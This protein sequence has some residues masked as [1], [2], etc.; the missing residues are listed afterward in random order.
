MKR[1]DFL[2][3]SAI[4]LLPL[5]GCS[6]APT[7]RSGRG[8]AVLPSFNRGNLSLYDWDRRTVEEFAMP[9]DLT[10]SALHNPAT[11]E[12]ILFEN[13]G[14]TCSVFDLST[15]KIR[16]T[17]RRNDGWL[18]YGHGAL[19]PGGHR[20][21][22]TEF[23]LDF[24][25]TSPGKLTVRDPS[26]LEILS[27]LPSHGYHPHDLCFLDEDTI[28]VT[29]HGSG[30]ANKSNVSFISYKTGALLGR[31]EFD[32]PNGNFGHLIAY[33]KDLSLIHI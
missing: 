4:L 19:S 13:I 24:Y 26:S 20:L 2:K 18:F 11:N 8:L 32:Q 5:P 16:K 9:M 1:R 27:E 14:P 22:C 7:K 6:L 3:A 15:R 31:T 30:P 17:L 12:L 33:G 10:H 25:S 23:A 29:N 28:A 21:V